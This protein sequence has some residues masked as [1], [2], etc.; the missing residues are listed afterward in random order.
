MKQLVYRVNGLR[1][2]TMMVIVICYFMS[3]KPTTKN[4]LTKWQANL[5]GVDRLVKDAPSFAAPIQAVKARA[6]AA[7]AEAEKVTEEEKKAE[8]MNGANQIISSGFVGK[9]M[10]I[11]RMQTEIS[12]LSGNLRRQASNSDFD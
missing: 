9:L 5:A 4:E 12:D 11:P 7:W 3:C 10:S 1:I 6:E 2:I 8:A